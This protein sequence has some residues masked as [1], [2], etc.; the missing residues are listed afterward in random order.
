M[1][2]DTRT[3]A[4]VQPAPATVPAQAGGEAPPDLPLRRDTEIQGDI[5][6]GFKKDHVQFLLLT[7]GDGRRARRW[8]G[9]LRHRI[10]T[11]KEVA[12][13]NTDF[14]RARRNS[15][16]D[17]PRTLTA[18]WRAVGFTHA[19]LT[20]LIGGAPYDDMPAGSTPEAFAQGMAAR[21]S[22]LGDVGQNAP[23]GW[24]FGA[25][26]TA[27]I[28]AVLTVAADRLEDLNTALAR[29]RQEAAS[30]QV[31]VSFEQ[32]GATLEGERSGKEH[33]GFKD[34][35]SQPAV[36]GFDEPEP[37]DPEHQYGKPGTRIVPAGEFVT[38]HPTDHRLGPF[39][40]DWMANGS[41]QVVRRLGQDVP[42]WW[43]QVADQLKVLK[44]QGVVPEEAGSEWLAAR[45]VGRWRSGAPVAKHPD[46]DPGASPTGGDDNDVIFSD[47]LEGRVTPLCAHMR[48]CNPRDG[49]MVNLDDEAPLAQKG[50]LDGR[51]IMRRGIPY[52]LP[53]DPAAGGA[54]GPDAPRGLVFVCYQGDLISQFEFIQRAWIDTDDFPNRDVP[55]GRDALLGRDSEVSFPV[56]G[57]QG[58]ESV[59]LSL[60]QFVKT[61]GS[62]YTFT[63]SMTALRMLADGSI[64]PGGGPPRDRVIPAFAVIGRGEVIS[65]G[66]ARLR[67]E[68]D[69]NLVLRDENEQVRWDAGMGGSTGVRGEM[70]TD[71]ALVLV[72]VNGDP[73]WSTGTEGNPGAVLVAR[74]DGDLAVVAP[75]G[76][77]LWHTDTA[78]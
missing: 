12:A 46:T 6:A 35:V 15:C 23:S 9:R 39:L 60:R 52:G 34:A 78:H 8:L 76:T 16:G 70:R 56:P 72:D 37:G 14:S 51:R 57:S 48:K 4:T 73:L 67:Y 30:Y 36:A 65:S 59:R 20:S 69:N 49:L 22:L 26:H 63:P 24:L 43:A 29:E 2:P 47:D 42:G 68:G 64:P 41:F 32:Y 62:L 45:F 66:K 54:N 1:S 21:A 33:F 7:F 3:T 19:G 18:V 53:F 40:P 55:V 71:G 27:P 77:T 44:E 25:P 11:T 5:V 61:E 75:D 50:A 74:A 28:H 58:T 31:A 17:D 13:F 10:A 38:G